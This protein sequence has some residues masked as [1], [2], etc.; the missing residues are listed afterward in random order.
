MVEKFPKPRLQDA[1]LALARSRRLQNGT[2]L[3]DIISNA[4]DRDE[5]AM[6]KALTPEAVTQM[7]GLD[8]NEVIKK[9]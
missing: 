8:F 7:R 1:E 2:S 6:E 5:T 9:Q 4:I 3:A